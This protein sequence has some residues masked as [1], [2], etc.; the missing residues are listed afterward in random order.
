MG[1]VDLDYIFPGLLLCGY[2]S[3][4]PLFVLSHVS[5]K[6]VAPSKHAARVLSIVKLAGFFLSCLEPVDSAR[7][8]SA[9][10]RLPG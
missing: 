6:S 4:I 1:A 8:Q 2:H 10:K 5:G 7:R 3:L 9:V